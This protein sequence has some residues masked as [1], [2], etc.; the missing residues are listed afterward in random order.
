MSEHR[1]ET[2]RGHKKDVV[3]QLIGASAAAEKEAAAARAAAAGQE[4]EE[5]EEEALLKPHTIRCG[6]SWRQMGRNCG[7]QD[8]AV[9]PIIDDQAWPQ[10]TVV[11]VMDTAAASHLSICQGTGALDSP[12]LS[13]LACTQLLCDRLPK[14]VRRATVAAVHHA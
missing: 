2:R 10:P 14:A 9:T 11:H 1:R 12:T 3:R 13:L 6:S 7:V 8:C 5:E 4:E